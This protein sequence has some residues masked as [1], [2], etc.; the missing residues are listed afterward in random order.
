MGITRP[1]ID[2]KFGPKKDLGI[3]SKCGFNDTQQGIN[4]AVT[5]QSYVILVALVKC[6]KFPLVGEHFHFL[7]VHVSSNKNSIPN[8]LI[9]ILKVITREIR[10]A[11]K[12]NLPAVLS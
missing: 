7:G 12:G 3:V 1:R 2:D 4:K 11:L 8:E 9:S 6:Y 5:A 10:E